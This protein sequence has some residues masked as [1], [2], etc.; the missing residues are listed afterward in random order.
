MVAT[1][2]LDAECAYH[3]TDDTGELNGF[4]PFVS[5]TGADNGGC[6]GCT[7]WS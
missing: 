1:L 3:M 5:D 7:N 6:R 4:E 2:S